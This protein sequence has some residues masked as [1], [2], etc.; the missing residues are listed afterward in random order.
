MTIMPLTEF[1]DNN[2]R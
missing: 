2:K 1:D